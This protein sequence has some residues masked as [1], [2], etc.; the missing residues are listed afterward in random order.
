ML[1]L[2]FGKQHMDIGKEYLVEETGYI[3]STDNKE[4][5]HYIR[6]AK[7]KGY[8]ISRIS[9]EEAVK[10]EKQICRECY[11]EN[12]IWDY[13]KQLQVT[14]TKNQTIKDWMVWDMMDTFKNNTHFE[15]LYVYMEST[16]KLHLRGDCFKKDIDTERTKLSDIKSVESICPSPSSAMCSKPSPTRSSPASATASNAFIS[17]IS[18][19]L[20]TTTSQG[21]QLCTPFIVCKRLSVRQCRQ[22]VR[23]RSPHGAR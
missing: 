19:I 12:E 10:E 14:V 3:H 7:N 21:V 22:P 4:K 8:T 13:I 9:K 20:Y 23:H 18:L 6:D 15:Y 2:I 17:R 11:P 5:C 16:G 1:V